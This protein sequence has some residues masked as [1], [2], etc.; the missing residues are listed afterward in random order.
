MKTS[1]ILLGVI[2]AGATVWAVV[3]QNES[4][5]LHTE[6][7]S[8]DVSIEDYDSRSGEGSLLFAPD[9]S[10]FSEPESAIVQPIFS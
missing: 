5:R 6:L 7:S 2:A 9:G 3:A 10:V 4:N 8:F 1:E